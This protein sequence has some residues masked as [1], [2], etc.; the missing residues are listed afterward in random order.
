MPSQRSTRHGVGHDGAAAT[1]EDTLAKAMRRKAKANL[2]FSSTSQRSKSFLAFPTPLI[3][4]NL[5]NVGLSSGNSATTISVSAAALSRMEFDRIK[6]APVSPSKPDISLSDEDDE[7]VYAV[8]DGQ[9]LSH[10]V[11]EVSEVGLDDDA[12]GSCFELQAT[13]R[14][15]RTSSI[16]R[17]AWPNK[18]AK[19]NKFVIVSK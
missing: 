5:N 9:L 2:D 3:A 18:N 8:L 4:T 14:K 7:D 1:D 16:K 10:L 19:V 17:N 15:S 13:A 11:G 6:V 12:L